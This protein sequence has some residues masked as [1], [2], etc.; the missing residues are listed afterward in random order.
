MQVGGLG[1]ILG[2]EQP[3]H[4]REISQEE[5]GVDLILSCTVLQE[6]VNVIIDTVC[7]S[8]KA[9]NHLL[10]VSLLIELT[11]RSNA[12]LCMAFL[13]EWLDSRKKKERNIPQR[14]IPSA[15]PL[16]RLLDTL[17]ENTPHDPVYLFTILT[18][19]ACSPAKCVD[20]LDVLNQ[21][22]AMVNWTPVRDLLF[23]KEDSG[24]ESYGEDED[25][26]VDIFTWKEGQSTFI[27]AKVTYCVPSLRFEE[28]SG[29][30]GLLKEVS[31]PQQ[32]SKGV[33]YD[34]AT[35]GREELLIHWSD[36]TLWW[37]VILDTISRAPLVA[38][39]ATGQGVGDYGRVSSDLVKTSVALDLLTTL[40]I[41]QPLLTG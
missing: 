7:L 23:L 12:D 24:S 34:V 8:H 3:F 13:S 26:W 28:E 18:S 33:V 11:Y 14:K 32:G 1:A 39:A 19:L 22:V 40:M 36:Q 41:R 2:K 35:D 5:G 16:G 15:S 20:V 10:N 30:T 29:K 38:A 37:G 21:Q 17:L 6:A 31:T 9:I 27:G 25:E 4:H